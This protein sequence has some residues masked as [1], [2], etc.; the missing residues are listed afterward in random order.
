MIYAIL[1]LGGLIIGGVIAW[2]ISEGKT[3]KKFSSRLDESERRASSAEGKIE[4]LRMQN[5]KSTEEIEKLQSSL[6]NER[7]ERV[8]A[9]TKLD[10][11]EKHLEEEKKLL[12]AVTEAMEEYGTPGTFNIGVRG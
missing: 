1:V 7:E 2:L 9:E 11:T 3:T 5:T 12:E 6:R 4:E 10:E 8:K